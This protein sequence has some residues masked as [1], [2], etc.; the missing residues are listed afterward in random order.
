MTNADTWLAGCERNFALKEV[1]GNGFTASGMKYFFPNS[2]YVYE[3]RGTA[4]DEFSSGW[5]G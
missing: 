3:P 4:S 2:F 1:G 5:E